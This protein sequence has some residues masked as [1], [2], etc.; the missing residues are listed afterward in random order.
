M[1]SVKLVNGLGGQ[2]S[3]A[4]STFLLTLIKFFNQENT[5]LMINFMHIM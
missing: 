5:L 1:L 2:V 4:I 3:V